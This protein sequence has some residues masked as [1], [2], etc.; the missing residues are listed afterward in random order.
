MIIGVEIAPNGWI[1]PIETT[2]ATDK[3]PPD[4]EAAKMVHCLVQGL[5]D[6]KSVV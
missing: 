1:W 4:V 2:K 5:I 3:T 6:R